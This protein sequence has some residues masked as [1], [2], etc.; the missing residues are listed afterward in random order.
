[1]ERFKNPLITLNFE[2]IALFA[3]INSPISAPAPSGDLRAAFANGNTTTVI[4]PSN[5]FFVF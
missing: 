1:M 3:T 4:S 2:T 5:S